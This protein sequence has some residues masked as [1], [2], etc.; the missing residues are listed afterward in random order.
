M[1]YRFGPGMMWGGMGLFWLVI[2]IA[3]IVVFKGLNKEDKINNRSRDNLETQDDALKIAKKRYAKG[4]ITKEEYQG[5]V[6]E[7][8]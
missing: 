6:E 3:I 4:E 2:I 8:K 1:G 7:L 5:I